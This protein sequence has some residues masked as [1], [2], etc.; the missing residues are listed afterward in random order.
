[1]LCC[2]SIAFLSR[3]EPGVICMIDDDFARAVGDKEE[4]AAPPPVGAPGGGVIKKCQGLRR[5]LAIGLEKTKTGSF[6]LHGHFLI[7]CH[8]KL[9]HRRKIR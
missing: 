1:M 7:F 9:G 4:V 8:A 3:P 5:G 2:A 6:F